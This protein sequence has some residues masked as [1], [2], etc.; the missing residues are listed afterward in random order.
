[1]AALPSEAER[2][3]AVPADRFVD[4]RKALAKRLRDEGRAD[5][6][7]AVEGLK[8]PSAVVLAVNRAA[9][10]R[11][12]AAENA[13]AAA[14]RVRDAQVAGDGNGFRAALADLDSALDL[15]ADVAVAQL[16][17]PGKSASEAMRR[18][19]RDLLRAAV[20]DDDARAAL[21][22]GAL[23][24]ELDA[25]GFSP[26]AAMP[27]PKKAARKKEPS[28]AER[29]EAEREAHVKELRD[30]LREAES[31]LDAATKAARDAEKK[32][33]SLRKKLERG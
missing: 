8:K 1:M 12:K 14:E 23:T 31:E 15:L 21:A 16:S 28:A 3:L 18:R 6:A 13:A 33:A 22:R 30:E 26:F 17:P 2:L 4:E 10:D 32:V 11:S 20:A 5:E 19:A 7:K 27:V 29:R 9:R 24:E 25:P